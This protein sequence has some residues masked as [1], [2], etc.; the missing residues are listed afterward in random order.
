MVPEIIF[1][2]LTA[3]GEF[4]VSREIENLECLGSTNTYVVQRL[5]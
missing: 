4:A 5:F 1:I 2:P 3:S